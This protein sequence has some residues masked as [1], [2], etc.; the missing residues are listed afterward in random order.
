EDPTKAS[1]EAPQQGIEIPAVFLR[2][3]NLKLK[4]LTRQIDLLKEFHGGGPRQGYVRMLG[5]PP[6]HL[7]PSS[8]EEHGPLHLPVFHNPK[9]RDFR[10]ADLR[11]QN[12]V[13]PHKH[14]SALDNPACG[15]LGKR[16]GG[17][18][19]GERFFGWLCIGHK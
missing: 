14:E 11:P 10:F 18:L 5:W 13:P 2:G 6:L 7:K 4:P 15:A 17:I 19:A 16:S 12:L 9:R 1:E 3:K 8:V